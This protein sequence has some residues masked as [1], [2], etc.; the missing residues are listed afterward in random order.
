MFEPSFVGKKF[1]SGDKTYEVAVADNFAYTDPVDGSVSKNQVSGPK[2]TMFLAGL[3]LTCVS[4]LFLDVSLRLVPLVGSPDHL[5]RRLQNYFPSQRH[6]QRRSNHQALHRQLRKGPPED[7]PGPAGQCSNT[8]FHHGPEE[9]NLGGQGLKSSEREMVSAP[10]RKICWK[11]TSGSVP[12]FH[13][14][15]RF[16]CL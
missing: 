3:G 11:F 14:A 6:R 7:L 12:C 15:S 10:V 4:D 2:S 13:P 9:K 5:L 8:C 1:S 16:Q